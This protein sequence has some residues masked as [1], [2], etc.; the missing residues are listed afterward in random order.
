MLFGAYYI[1][2]AARLTYNRFRWVEC[3][4]QDLRKCRSKN[5]IRAVLRNLPSTLEET[6]LSTLKHIEPKD[7]CKAIRVFQ[8]LCYFTKPV[9]FDYMRLLLA[10]NLEPAVPS[11]DLDDCFES[12]E[13]IV[14]ICPTF[15]KAFEES[16]SKLLRLTHFSIKEFL[17]RNT[18]YHRAFM[19]GQSSASETMTLTCIGCLLKLG[20]LDWYQKSQLEPRL[21]GTSLTLTADL[22]W[23]E[24][25]PTVRLRYYLIGIAEAF[26]SST[27]HE[28]IR[29]VS[30][31]TTI[32]E[33]CAKLLSSPRA[34][35]LY[36]RNSYEAAKD[37]EIDLIC[38]DLPPPLH[39]L[40]VWDNLKLLKAVIRKLPATPMDQL[41][42]QHSFDKRRD[43]TRSDWSDTTALHIA[44]I[45]NLTDMTEYLLERGIAN[46]EQRDMASE[47]ALHT[48]VRHNSQT[49]AVALISHGA[50]LKSQNT[51]FATPLMVYL[52]LQYFEKWTPTT[53]KWLELLGLGQKTYVDFSG[54][55]MLHVLARYAGIDGQ[56]M[57][58]YSKAGVNLM[59]Q[60]SVGWTPLRRAFVSGHLTN[61]EALLSLGCR[62]AQDLDHFGNTI[63]HSLRPFISGR[64]IEFIDELG[65]PY[66]SLYQSHVQ[67]EDTCIPI[68]EIL[69]DNGVNVNT[70]NNAGQTSLEVW[71]VALKYHKTLNMDVRFVR[72]HTLD[73]I[74]EILGTSSRSISG[75]SLMGGIW[76]WLIKRTRKAKTAII[77]GLK[78][79]VPNIVNEGNWPKKDY[80][81]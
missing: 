71:I 68:M 61:I 19:L 17:L 13:D 33:P 37:A 80:W 52:S 30:D 18:Y 1:C 70:L 35:A 21:S 2:W 41:W 59:L 15:L 38:R 57:K 69:T 47:T 26:V 34:L 56:V 76:S 28:S 43:L 60:D 58:N 9:P 23:I 81:V 54:A 62:P 53:M 11:L 74:A 55:T 64:N 78:R 79:K 46:V 51:I 6:Y 27:L 49:C 4:L 29:Y 63:L 72:K 22:A 65:R 31:V 48:A 75:L 14:A 24:S 32:T 67:H 7:Y 12:L 40:V 50:S 36:I 16:G 45:G 66:L 3:Q 20:G 8:L 10:V 5:E 25:R 42:L 44:S 39:L 77:K 73:E